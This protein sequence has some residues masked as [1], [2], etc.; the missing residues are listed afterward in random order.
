VQKSVV[1]KVY[2]TFTTLFIM[3]KLKKVI[4]CILL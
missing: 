4:N 1:I 2:I 3:D